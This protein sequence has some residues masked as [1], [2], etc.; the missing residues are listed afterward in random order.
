[1]SKT[2]FGFRIADCGLEDNALAFRNPGYPLG[3]AIRNRSCRFGLIL[4]SFAAFLAVLSGCREPETASA[5]RTQ[6]TSLQRDDRGEALIIAA[7]QQLGDLPSAVDTELRPPTVILDAN[8]SGTGADV[9]AIAVANPNIPGNPVNL[10]G[11]PPD[12]PGRF[13]SL[14]VRSGDILKYYIIEDETV[15]EERQLTGFARRL[16]KELTIGQVI[17]DNSLI[18]EGSLPEQ[19][20]FPA[21]LEVWRNL[22]DRL[23]E[24]NRKLLDYARKQQPP[25]GWE[26][27]PDERVLVQIVAWLNQWL[28]Q[29]EPKTDWKRDALIDTLPP[30]LLSNENLSSKLDAKALAAQVFGPYD[31]QLL[32]E[33]VW[34]RDISRWA[35]GDDFND[36]AR[37]TALFDWTIRNVQ[38]V[39]DENALPHRPWRTLVDGRGTA[40]ERAWVY[41]LLC[42]QQ[43]LD[44]VML[45]VPVVGDQQSAKSE[46]TSPQHP[47]PSPLPYY[48]PALVLDGQLY[49]FDTRLG[50]PIPGPGGEGVATLAQVQQDDA[51]LRQLDLD[52]APYPLKSEALK[53]AVARV[54]VS[55]FELSR[56]AMQLESKLTGDNHLVLTVVPSNVVERLKTIPT[57][58]GV[59]LWDVPFRTLHEQ[60]SLSETERTLEA[61]AFEP[62]AKR[63]LLWKARMRHFQG[64]RER[65]RK[66]EDDGVDDHREAVQLYTNPS[67]RPLDTKIAQVSSA[68]ERRVDTTAKRAATYWV[69]LLSFDEGKFNIAEDWLR[70]SGLGDDESPWSAGTR[71]NLARALEA[72][73]EFD[74][75]VKLLEEDTSP[76]RH[77]NQLRA[78]MLRA[79]AAKA[80]AE[81]DEAR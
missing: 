19:V 56:R 18:I 72:Q 78:R 25:L 28:R 55:P 29:V 62:F 74:E 64:R 7:A 63:P 6:Q 31:E 68:D 3:A 53:N 4:F 60:L 71:Y 35:Q 44:V 8:K 14:G 17:D 41:A 52:G 66:S 30:D 5:T 76:Q 43:A 16:A 54:V 80:K 49:L 15:D 40:D 51:I 42:R 13:K 50:L 61:L 81:A 39:P 70:R 36:L 12:R 27:G 67:V 26:P 34:L 21:K 77:G 46:P 65:D 59:A 22:D 23:E 37:A 33:A 20:L 2:D 58:S 57:L 69:G 1:L 79:K 32:Q 47:V 75:A 10:I 11:V 24:I 38:L 9:V 48:L 73:D 45:E